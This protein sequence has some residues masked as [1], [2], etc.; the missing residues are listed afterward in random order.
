MIVYDRIGNLLNV[1]DKV[2]HEKNIWVIEKIKGSNIYLTRYQ[3]RA[4][5]TSDQIQKCF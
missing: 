3:Q 4:K 1:G 2:R 5:V